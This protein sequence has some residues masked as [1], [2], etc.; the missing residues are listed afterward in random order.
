MRRLRYAAF[1]A[2]L[3]YFFDPDNGR[4]RRKAAIKRLAELR[5]R[6][7]GELVDDLVDQTRAPGPVAEPVQAPAPE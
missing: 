7:Q 3:A 1:G 2:A 6:H 4:S 5:S